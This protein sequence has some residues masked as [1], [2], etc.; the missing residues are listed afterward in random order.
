MQIIMW[1]TDA[2]DILFYLGNY[3]IVLIVSWSIGGN[4]TCYTLWNSSIFSGQELQ[5]RYLESAPVVALYRAIIATSLC[6][7]AAKVVFER[8]I[9][10]SA[11]MI[12]A[13]YSHNH[14]ICTNRHDR[15]LSSNPTCCSR[16]SWVTV[17]VHRHQPQLQEPLLLLAPHQSLPAGCPAVVKSAIFSN[18]SPFP[19]HLIT[20][21]R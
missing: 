3:G 1:M 4:E 9:I 15:I 5:G 7:T 2:S 14:L 8:A 19:S 11:S 12:N 18:L 21:S 13:C 10:H 20:Y 6:Y 16:S 17:A